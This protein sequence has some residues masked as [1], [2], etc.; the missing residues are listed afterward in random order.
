MDLR[1]RAGLVMHDKL[2]GIIS[3]VVVCGIVQGLFPTKKT[4]YMRRVYLVGDLGIPS[5]LVGG[6]TFCSS[7]TKLRRGRDF[8]T[9][10]NSGMLWEEYLLRIVGDTTKLGVSTWHFDRTKVVSSVRQNL[11]MAPN[12]P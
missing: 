3:F 7:K 8:A 11:K 2:D 9:P 1:R 12:R 4:Y 5:H 6:L 10:S